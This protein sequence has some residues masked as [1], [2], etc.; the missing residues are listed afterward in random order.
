MHNLLLLPCLKGRIEASRLKG[1]GLREAGRS[2][3]PGGARTYAK[4]SLIFLHLM[5]R[6]VLVGME[7]SVAEDIPA[8]ANLYGF[9]IH[10]E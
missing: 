10:A 4:P 6:K 9:F 8:P 2:R 1:R 3:G 7:K 5:Q